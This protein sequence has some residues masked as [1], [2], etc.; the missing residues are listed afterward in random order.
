MGSSTACNKAGPEHS[1]QF[2]KTMDRPFL[3]TVKPSHHHGLEARR[4]YLTYKSIILRVES[5]ELSIMTY[6]LHRVGLTV[7][8]SKQRTSKMLGHL[9]M[10]Y[11]FGEW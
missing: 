5:H 11:L 8:T 7:I 4:E 2:A 6:V 9:S 10:L 1:N 3:Q